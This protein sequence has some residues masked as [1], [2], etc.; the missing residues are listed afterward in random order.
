[1]PM[2]FYLSLSKYLTCDMCWCFYHLF[3]TFCKFLLLYLTKFNIFIDCFLLYSPLGS[4]CTHVSG[5]WRLMFSL[6][7]VFLMT[8]DSVLSKECYFMRSPLEEGSC[9][10]YYSRCP[11][12][13]K[14]VEWRRLVSALHGIV[15]NSQHYHNNHSW[16]CLCP[17][18][19]IIP[20]RWREKYIF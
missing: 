12:K 19:H 18:P 17:V 6:V 1:M 20:Y 10:P 11:F 7:A 8:P 9:Y 2:W 4:W 16:P 3:L 5:L 15:F 14:K 13:L